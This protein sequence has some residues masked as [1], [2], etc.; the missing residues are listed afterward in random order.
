MKPP[1]IPKILQPTGPKLPRGTRPAK[2]KKKKPHTKKPRVRHGYTLMHTFVLTAQSGCT[3]PRR[4]RGRP[5]DRVECLFP[6]TTGGT[7]LHA[8]MDT[9]MQSRCMHTDAHPLADIR[10]HSDNAP[11]IGWTEG[12]RAGGGCEERDTDWGLCQHF[13]PY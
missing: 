9:H 5:A 13:L 1:L 12:R 11:I 10:S 4:R 7:A 2:K 3:V 6:S 8:H